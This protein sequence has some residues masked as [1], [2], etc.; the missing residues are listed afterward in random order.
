MVHEHNV[1]HD[2]R[3][4]EFNVLRMVV[5]VAVVKL[6]VRGCHVFMNCTS[7]KG[8]RMQDKKKVVYTIP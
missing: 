4:A 5:V 1:E 8:G 7:E 2:A 3:V 6:H